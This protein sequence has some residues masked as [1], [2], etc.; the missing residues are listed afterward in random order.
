VDKPSQ[1]IHRIMCD[2][3]GGPNHTGILGIGACPAHNIAGGNAAGFIA[4][5]VRWWLNDHRSDAA[6]LARH[7]IAAT[8]YFITPN[9]NLAG[10]K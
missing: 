3:L 5:L 4:G 7:Q 8:P 6:Q 1:L 9:F 10:P 2:V